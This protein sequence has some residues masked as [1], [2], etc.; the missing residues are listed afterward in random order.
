M[1]T[2]HKGKKI[3]EKFFLKKGLT[4][5]VMKIKKI[6]VVKTK[7]DRFWYSNHIGEEFLVVDAYIGNCRSHWE[8]GVYHK[9]YYEVETTRPIFKADCE[10]IPSLQPFKGGITFKLK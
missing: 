1:K 5:L 7:D 9:L 10:N 8:Q 6:R 2:I 3:P 4:I